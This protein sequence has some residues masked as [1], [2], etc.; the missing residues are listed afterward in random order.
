MGRRGGGDGSAWVLYVGDYLV[1]CFG[2]FLEGGLGGGVDG[3]G[4]QFHVAL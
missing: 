4:L 2:G 1:R 3:Q